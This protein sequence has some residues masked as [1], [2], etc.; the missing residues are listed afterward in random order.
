MINSIRLIF[1]SSCILFWFSA[2]AQRVPNSTQLKCATPDLTTAQLQALNNQAAFALKIKQASGV[3]QTGIKYVPIRPH[4]F[5]R[6][7]G[8]GGMALAKLN[9]IIAL[10]NS[11]YLLN[12]SGIQFYLAGTTPDYIDND[13]LYTSFPAYN[14]TSVE[15]RDA[16]N[17][18]NQYYVNAF[19]QNNLG[20]Y[21]HFPNIDN[22][23]STRSFIL[24]E[25]DE[26][27]LGNRLIPHELGHS[28]SLY[29]TFGNLSSGTDELVTRGT[30]ANC[31]T[32][33]DELCDTPADPY[34]KTGATTVY[35][36]GCETYNGI[37][38]DAQGK[39]YSPS[40]TNIMSYYF[41]CTHDFT[42][43]QYER[44]QA[45]LA[46]RQTHT[47]YSLNYPPTVV[48]APTNVSAVIN[49]GN[50]VLTWQDNGTN[51]MGYFIERS[52]SG[53]TGFVPVGGVATDATTYTDT[54]AA[55]LTTYYYRVRPSNSTTQGISPV[56]SIATPACHPF[57]YYN[58]ADG[59][60]LKSLVVNGTVLS[61]NSGCSLGGYSSSTVVSGTVTSGQSVT[62]TG[63]LLNSTYSEGVAIWADLNRNGLFETSQNELLYQ[64][65]S[66]TTA[67]FSGSLSF[68][69]SLTAGPIAIRVVVAYNLVPSDPCG[70]YTY[71][72]TEDY[73]L[74]VVNPPSADLS[75]SIQASNRTPLVNQTMSVSVTIQNNGPN[76]A[77]GISWQNRLPST[78]SFVSGS[79]G[80]VSSGTAIGGSGIAINSGASATFSYQVK[81]TQA[82]TYLNAAQIITSNQTDPD[83]QPG[84]GTGDGQDDTATLDIRTPDSSTAIYA[85][86]NPNQTPLPAVSSNQPAPDPTKADLSLAL[87]V[88]T[89]TPKS[90][91]PVTFSVIVSNAGG[92]TAS[93]VVVRD[94]LWGM[95]FVGSPSG[96]SVVGSG[97]GY[98]IVQATIAS[99]AAGSSARLVFTATPTSTGHSINSAQIWSSTPSDPDS[100]P[101]SATPTANNL[102]GEDDTASIDLRVGS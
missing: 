26:N 53:T 28:F 77:T 63:T 69:A 48:A 74:L 42:P 13:A 86:P 81:P 85:S 90:G 61:Q 60:G 45:G 97:N 30:G 22:I 7:D 73:Q 52:T 41:P 21:A 70:I 68:P 93:T 100:T 18:M 36:N 32:A 33:G 25:S 95:T 4:I 39:P 6:S 37:A 44:I 34:G 38:K 96:V 62:F 35:I 23:Q 76:N 8:T 91:Q 46:L 57:Y 89:R 54:K 98:S 87:S 92:S 10:T 15:G 72:E 75:L 31:A 40:M 78:L 29:H 20:G 5:R 50:V 9:N 2:S 82:G 27:D 102:N 19:D 79:A 64:T 99:I 11:Y 80:V 16:L 101:G 94:T 17:A 1:I 67:P 56:V 55:P 3:G 88:D 84:S 51:E 43:G 14:E 58:C 24:N 66:S 12:G 49:S 83:S 47:S 71:G 65:P 59:D